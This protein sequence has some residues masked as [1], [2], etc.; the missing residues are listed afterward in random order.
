MPVAPTEVLIGG[1]RAH[2][3]RVDCFEVRPSWHEEPQQRF[4]DF[5]SPVIIKICIFFKETKKN[6]IYF[7]KKSIYSYAVDFVETNLIQNHIQSLVRNGAN[8][9]P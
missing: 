9:R 6:L 1:T 7:F 3:L 8:E 2:H 5:A 4:C